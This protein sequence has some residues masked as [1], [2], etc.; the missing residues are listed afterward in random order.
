MGRDCPLIG[1]CRLS[2]GFL[3]LALLLLLRFVVA[4]GTTRSRAQSRVMS[5]D[6]PGDAADNRA[7]YTSLSLCGQRGDYGGYCG[8]GGYGYV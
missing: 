5:R 3:S 2:F 4:D 1:G 8:K 6:V 7:L